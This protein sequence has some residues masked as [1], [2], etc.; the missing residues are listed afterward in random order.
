MYICELM[1]IY[2][3]WEISLISSHKGKVKPV[4]HISL[5]RSL[6]RKTFRLFG[7]LTANHWFRLNQIKIIAT[8]ECL[9]LTVDH[10]GGLY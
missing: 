8:N 9:C 5:S 3:I 2:S 6:G 4:S 1:D 7:P 10:S